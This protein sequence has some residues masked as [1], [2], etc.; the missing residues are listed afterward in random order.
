MVC[1]SRRFARLKARAYEPT[2]KGSSADGGSPVAEAAADSEVESSSRGSDQISALDLYERCAEIARG[3]GDFERRRCIFDFDSDYSGRTRS[4]A[5]IFSAEKPMTEIATYR[6]LL[7]AARDAQR[8]MTYA[9]VEP[10]PFL[11]EGTVR[12]AERFFGIHR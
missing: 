7:T 4:I 2:P 12:V 1:A 5:F 6:R 10:I 8:C 11:T 9:P 3:V